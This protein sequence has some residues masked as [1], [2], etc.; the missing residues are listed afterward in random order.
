MALVPL[1]P[2]FC[3]DDANW[4]LERSVNGASLAR[5]WLANV[6]HVIDQPMLD[7]HRGQ[8]RFSRAGRCPRCSK[9]KE[10]DFNPHPPQ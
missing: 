9:E 7:L 4:R 3:D 6:L 10:G 8:H 1:A 2:F 5:Q